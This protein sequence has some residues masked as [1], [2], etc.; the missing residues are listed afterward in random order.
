[1][2]A[3]GEALTRKIPDWLRWILVPFAAMAV[4]VATFLEMGLI[5]SIVVLTFGFYEDSLLDWLRQFAIG[6]SLA[7]FLAVIVG[8][9]VAPKHKFASSLILGAAFIILGAIGM[10]FFALVESDFGM[11]TARLFWCLGAGIAIL[12]VRYDK[13]TGFSGVLD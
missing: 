9:H 1:M 6:P 7:T 2:E 12:T 5:W 11:F 8:V 3:D 10:Y 4:N 13:D